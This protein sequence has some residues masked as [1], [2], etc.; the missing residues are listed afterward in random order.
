MSG[1]GTFLDTAMKYDPQTW[2]ILP[3]NPKCLEMLE[4]CFLRFDWYLEYLN[5][6]SNNLTP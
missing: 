4:F 3:I 5:C 6:D 2:E 1:N